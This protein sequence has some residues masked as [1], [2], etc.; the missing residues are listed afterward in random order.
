LAESAPIVGGDM[1][2]IESLTFALDAFGQ[3]T[4]PREVGRYRGAEV[5]FVSPPSDER[6]RRV[7]L[8]GAGSV[9]ATIERTVSTA[10]G[11]ERREA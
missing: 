1:V 4:L 2:R 11:S 9:C 6:T 3:P 5:H 10:S 8:E 7:E